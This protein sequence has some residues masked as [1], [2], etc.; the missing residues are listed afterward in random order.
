MDGVIYVY[1]LEKD[2]KHLWPF[3]IQIRQSQPS[4]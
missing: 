3:E 2:E 1:A 4:A